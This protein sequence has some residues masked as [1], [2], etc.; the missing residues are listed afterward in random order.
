MPEEG[1]RRS[2]K[3]WGD[4]GESSQRIKPKPKGDVLSKLRTLNARRLRQSTLL[5][6][7]FQLDYCFQEK[8]EEDLKKEIKK[9]QEL[10]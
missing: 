9:L 3:V 1:D 10:I 5:S 8:Y 7:M 4:L 6:K 2:R